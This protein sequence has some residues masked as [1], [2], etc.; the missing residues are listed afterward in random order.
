MS[1]LSLVPDDEHLIVLVGLHQVQEHVAS[2]EIILRVCRDKRIADTSRYPD[3][4]ELT[5]SVGRQVT[6]WSRSTS[7]S[8]S[9]A[10]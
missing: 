7:A 9:P 10:T 6:A 5:Q 4:I 2:V 1:I 8:S 3:A